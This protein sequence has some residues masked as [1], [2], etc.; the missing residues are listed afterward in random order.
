MGCA[1]LQH[2]L[3]MDAAAALRGARAMAVAELAV[4]PRLRD[5]MRD[6]FYNNAAVST[7]VPAELAAHAPSACARGSVGLPVHM[8]RT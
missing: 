1:V 3:R 4:E 7:G 8:P 5:A 2:G 6:L